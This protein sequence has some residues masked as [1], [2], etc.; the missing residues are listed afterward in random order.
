MLIGAPEG[1]HLEGSIYSTSSKEQ[2]E[3]FRSCLDNVSR[4]RLGG[5]ERSDKVAERHTTEVLIR[6]SVSAQDVM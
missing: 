4:F 1:T 3:P 6:A 5:N 2:Q